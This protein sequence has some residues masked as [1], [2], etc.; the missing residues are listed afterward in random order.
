MNQWQVDVVHQEYMRAEGTT[1]PLC[2]LYA[3]AYQQ[4]LKDIALEFERHDFFQ[5]ARMTRAF[6]KTSSWQFKEEPN[7]DE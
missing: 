1:R 4:A 5:E 6:A 7:V 3:L 2:G